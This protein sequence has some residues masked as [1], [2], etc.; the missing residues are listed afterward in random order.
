L[1]PLDFL[2]QQAGLLES[3][4]DQPNQPEKVRR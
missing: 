4:G 3:S 1:G 2:I